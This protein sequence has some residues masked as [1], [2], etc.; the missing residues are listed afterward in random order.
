MTSRC[1]HRKAATKC[2]MSKQKRSH[3]LLVDNITTV[4]WWCHLLCI[5][6]MSRRW[7]NHNELSTSTQ[8]GLDWLTLHETRELLCGIYTFRDHSVH[9]HMSTKT[10]L[11]L[12]LICINYIYALYTKPSVFSMTIFLILSTMFKNTDS[13]NNIRIRLIAKQDLF[14]LLIVSQVKYVVFTEV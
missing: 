10:Q 8:G 3:I 12:K 7:M 13:M 14:W 6:A 4:A 5:S 1:S 11:Q 2:E 9:L